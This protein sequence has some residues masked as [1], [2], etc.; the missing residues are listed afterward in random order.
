MYRASAF[1]IES[2]AIILKKH[3]DPTQTEVLCPYCGQKT[4]V[5]NLTYISGFI[6]CSDA[7]FEGGCFWYPKYGLKDMAEF[8]KDYDYEYFSKGDWYRKGFAPFD[9]L[10]IQQEEIL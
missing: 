6:G 2:D 8:L 1:N 7:P 3:Q 9:Q 10:N 4:I 5:A